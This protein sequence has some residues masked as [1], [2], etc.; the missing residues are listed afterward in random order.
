MNQYWTRV[1]A[2][3]KTKS[4]RPLTKRDIALCVF[5]TTFYIVAGKWALALALIE[6]NVTAIWLPSGIAL[7]T[8]ILLGYRVW[9][10]ILVGSLIMDAIRVGHLRGSAFGVAA[11]NIL[12]GFVG[13]YLVSRFARGIRFQG[14][15]RSHPYDAATLRATTHSYSEST[16]TAYRQK[17]RR[18][19]LRAWLSGALCRL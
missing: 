10:A 19:L 14:P 18:G 5:L 7:A 3:I 12:E 9:P 15:I 6:P 11:A 17:L 16:D 4:A 13:C 1:R 8:F 2:R